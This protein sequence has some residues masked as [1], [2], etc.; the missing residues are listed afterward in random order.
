M[1]NRVACS[2]FVQADPFAEPRSTNLF[3][4]K[5][6]GLPMGRDIYYAVHWDSDRDDMDTRLTIPGVAGAAFILG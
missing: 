3:S 4:G 6:I 5:A 1:R 2:F